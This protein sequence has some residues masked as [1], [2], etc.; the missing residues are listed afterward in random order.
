MELLLLLWYS[1]LRI[2][3]FC[4]L[5]IVRLIFMDSNICHVFR[6][7]TRTIFAQCSRVCADYVVPL[8][9]MMSHQCTRL[10]VR[11]MCWWAQKCAGHIIHIGWCFLFGRCIGYRQQNIGAQRIIRG[12]SRWTLIFIYNAFALQTLGQPWV[13]HIL[14]IFVTYLQF[15]RKKKQRNGE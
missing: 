6:W 7:S 12:T 3:H 15:N 10:A 8:R 1:C 11:L 4:V 2:D 14:L 13:A 9:L 5:E